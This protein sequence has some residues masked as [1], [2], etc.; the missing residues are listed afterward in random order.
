MQRY[1][2]KIRFIIGIKTTSN[3]HLLT[4]ISS[5]LLA[6]FANTEIPRMKQKIDQIAKNGPDIDCK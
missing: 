6:P 2:V 1:N 4:R 3:D 5:S